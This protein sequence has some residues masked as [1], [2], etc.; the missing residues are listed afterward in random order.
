MEERSARRRFRALWQDHYAEIFAY[1]ARRLGDDA[2]ADDAVAETFLVAWRK[3]G[4]MPD[5]PRP[6][7]FGVARKVVAQQRRGERRRDALTARLGEHEPP[8]TADQSSETA[9]PVVEAFNRLRAADRE[10]LSLVVWEE[11][12][13]REAARVLGIAVPLLSVRLHRAKQRLR[14]EVDRAGGPTEA[15]DADAPA[16]RGTSSTSARMEAR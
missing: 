11:L 6:W 4:A 9:V 7:L 15:P 14:R 13:A 3:L 5:D 10:I 2:A 8:P 12:T 1:A 16:A